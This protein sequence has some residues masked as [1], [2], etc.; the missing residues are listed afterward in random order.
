MRLLLAACCATGWMMAQEVTGSIVGTVTDKTGLPV[1]NA[2]I[3]I[4]AIDQAVNRAYQT[5]AEGNYAATLLSIGRYSIRAEAPGFKAALRSG[6]DL[7]ASDKLTA[8]FSLEVGD[9]ATTVEVV[10]ESVATVELQS[11]TSAGLI[12]GVE[13]K[14]LALNNRNYIQLISLMPGVTNNSPTDEVYIGTT[15]P[16]GSTNTIPFSL[17]GGRTSGN[18]FMVDGADNVDRGSNLTLLNYPSVDAIAEFKALRGQYSAEFGRGAAG[19][20]NVIT[21]SGTAKFHGSAYEFFRND[22]L[23]ANTYFNNARRIARPPLRYNNFGYTIGGPVPFLGTRKSDRNKTFFFWSHEFRRVLTYATFNALAPTEDLKQ[24]IFTAPVCTQFTGNTCEATATRIT[25]I[26]PVA[27]AYLQSVW[28]RIP[29]G[30]PTTYNLFTPQ[31]SIYNARQELIKIDHVFTASHQVSVRYIS[32]TIPTEEPGGLFTGAALPGVSTTRTNSPGRGWMFRGTST[33][34][35]TLLNEAG[36]AYSSGA[37]TSTP[38]GLIAAANSPAVQVKL[39]FASTLNRIPSLSVAGFS[40]VTGFG[41]YENYN[42]NYNF[43]DNMTKVWSRRV[44]KFGASVNLYQKN[45]NAAG[46]NAGTFSIPNTPR[47]ST[48][49]PLAQQAW[50]NFLLG[51][52]S[53]YTQASVD[54]F[55]DV[56]QR[57]WELYFQDD[58]RVKPNF[59]L[60]LGVRYS[61][62]YLPYDAAG[63]L[64]NFDPSR[65]DPAKAPQVNP[66][67]GNVVPNTGDEL[68]GILINNRNSPFG[69]KISNEDRHKFAPR[70]GF[71]WDPFKKGRTAIRS[72]YGISYDST[73]VGIYEQ[74]IFN[75]PP[76]VNS[77]NISN[78]RLENPAAGVQVISAAPK[79]LRGT[80]APNQ[81]PYTQQWS[82]DI[83]HQLVKNLVASVGYYGSKS[84][85][86][87]GVVDI[88]QV[89]VGAAVAA[90]ITDANTPFTTQ[91]TP[92]LNVIRPYRGYGPINTVQNWFNSNY[93]SLQVS[94]QKYYTGGFS[95]R[96]S[97][98]WSKVMT[99][100]TSDRS[101][102]PQNTYNRSAERARALFDRPH[103]LTISYIYQV[104]L[105]A[106]SHGTTA[107]AL[108]GWQLS[109]I[110]TFNSGTPLRVTS[111]LGQD[112]GGLGILGTSASSPR[113]DRISDPNAGAPHTL[114]KW[115]NTEAFAAV[116]QGEVRPG[117]AGPATVVGP[118]FFRYDL[119]MF[120]NIKWGERGKDVQIRL[121]SFNTLNHT[122]FLG[123]STSLG[124]TNFGQVTSTREPRRVQLAMKLRF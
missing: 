87:L 112:W 94:A 16:T 111:G 2:K 30:D 43:F 44:W 31:R 104:P 84:T 49:T 57:Q 29:A 6:L 60:N 123:V 51:N 114:L 63:L 79:T 121:E 109:G 46:N 74:N 102:A 47:P 4:S 23:S 14:E 67:T 5:N 32:D 95:L 18:N 96:L 124:A 71:A 119:S 100:A 62:F 107:L 36:F 21:K 53:T 13:V 122:N 45:E 65:W 93:N 58:W 22:V 69:S 27:R 118:G 35:P 9:T 28:S 24:G 117:N 1:A 26:N 103:V 83:Q 77:I 33:V 54:L 116:P 99:D 90:G 113:P 86:L 92:R 55:P 52:V 40:S 50:A 8:N 110:A 88:N 11:A 34:R 37:I 66:T 10:G 15:N 17:N 61:N 82:F 75:N 106:K 105:A 97:Y 42:R 89:P 39:P 73:L 19:M 81:L 85:H 72:G 80:P 68:N 20:I 7:H 101:N 98:T 76:Y 70:I 115:F 25:N 3:T 91:T 78:T 48:A 41:Q 59:T 64:T 120:K 12:S 108:R 38:V 56:R